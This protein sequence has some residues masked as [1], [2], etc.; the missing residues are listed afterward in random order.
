MERDNKGK[1]I[2][3]GVE[4]QEEKIKKKYCYKGSLENQKRLYWR[5]K[6]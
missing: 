3:G 5:F 4:T 2:I 1:F 6:I